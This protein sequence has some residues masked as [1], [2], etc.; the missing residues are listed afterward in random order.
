MYRKGRKSIDHKREKPTTGFDETG[1]SKKRYRGPGGGGLDTAKSIEQTDGNLFSSP[2]TQHQP[3]R[4]TN[5]RRSIKSEDS[6][7]TRPTI[8]NQV[9]QKLINSVHQKN[10]QMDDDDDDSFFDPNHHFSESISKD[11]VVLHD[12]EMGMT[13]RSL[14]YKEI[15]LTD[16]KVKDV[17]I[18][19]AP[20]GSLNIVPQHSNWLIHNSK[21][22]APK[23]QP[24]PDIPV[25]QETFKVRD[26]DTARTKDAGKKA[27]PQPTASHLSKLQTVIT[28]KF[29]QDMKAKAQLMRKEKEQKERVKAASQGPLKS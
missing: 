19:N 5:P 1:M 22:H 12:D 4:Q 14:H 29:K 21:K 8:P 27:A 20:N 25:N 23:K 9:Q 26:L 11:D 3:R 28:A 18:Q 10:E 6:N 24:N 13:Q 16:T 2:T 7:F 15:N 17:I